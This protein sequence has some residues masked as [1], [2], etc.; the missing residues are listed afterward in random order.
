[1][2]ENA[3]QLALRLST[4]LSIDNLDNCVD[5][6]SKFSIYTILKEVT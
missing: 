3:E 5:I 6:K 4:L 2:R 1:L